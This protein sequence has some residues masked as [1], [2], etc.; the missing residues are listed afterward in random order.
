MFSKNLVRFYLL[1]SLF[2]GSFSFS[3]AQEEP[4]VKWKD[5]EKY[6]VH[7]IKKGD[8]WSGL[9][10]KYKTSVKLL[11]QINPKSMELKY[12]FVVLIPYDNY[13]NSIKGDNRV[14]QA[15]EKSSQSNS[16]ESGVIDS[17]ASNGLLDTSN[18]STNGGFNAIKKNA[19]K[20]K[21]NTKTSNE[22]IS[23]K[24]QSGETLFGIAKRYKLNY[25]DLAKFNSLKSTNVKAG[26]V[27]KIPVKYNA[28]ST[29]H[30]T[31]V[32]SDI[33]SDTGHAG[34]ENLQKDSS[35]TITSAYQEING[36][37]IEQGVATWLMDAGTGRNE[38]FY[39]LHRTA[40]IGTIIKVK[41]AMTNRSVFVKVV[42]VLPDT[43]DNHDVLIKITQSAARRIGIIDSRFRVE[44]S[45]KS[46]S[47]NGLS[48]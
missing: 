4:K 32:N 17:K 42:G 8:T 12:G 16:K 10:R 34:L 29:E 26:Q 20:N 11:Q 13:L 7:E 23:Y 27:I 18:T 48:K 43:G 19:D 41:N 39:A 40:P 24:V 36:T 1:L 2:L 22:T 15:N 5:G 35:S 9:S 38:K 14:V 33:K 3:F 46:K 44:I 6:I 25:N 37:I 45:Y 30:V 28:P 47:K 21:D 31:D